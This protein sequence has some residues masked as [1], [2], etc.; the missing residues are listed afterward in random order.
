MFSL[1]HGLWKYWFQKDEYCIVLLGL[2]NAGKTTFLERIKT[3]FNKNYK[4]TN[5]EKVVNSLIN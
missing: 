3:K 5:I 1:L 4:G 2:D